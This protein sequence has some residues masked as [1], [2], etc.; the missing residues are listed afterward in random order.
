MLYCVHS[1]KEL[2]ICG[3]HLL[4]MQPVSSATHLDASGHHEHHPFS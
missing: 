3:A 1:Y 4:L 2:N